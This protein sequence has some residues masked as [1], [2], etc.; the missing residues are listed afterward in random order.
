MQDRQTNLCN[1]VL[2]SEQQLVDLVSQR[3]KIQKGLMSTNHWDTRVCHS[4]PR[5]LS[6]CSYLNPRIRQSC[7]RLPL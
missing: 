7:S 2:V 3:K 6:L 1:L 4:F 5:N